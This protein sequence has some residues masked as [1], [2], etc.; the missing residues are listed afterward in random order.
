[1]GGPS[2]D[3]SADH[4]YLIEDFNDFQ[5][6]QTDPNY[7]ATGIHTRLDCDLDLDPNLPDRQIYITAVAPAL[8]GHFDG[9][10]HTI[11]NLII[12]SNGSN[13]SNDWWYVGLFGIIEGYD[14]VVE[15]LG[16]KNVN[17]TI[18]DANFSGEVG[19][20][21]GFNGQC[22]STDRFGG[23]ITNCYVTGTVVGG[24]HAFA[25]GGLCGGNWKGNINDC[26]TTVTV[27]GRDNSEYVGGICG[28]NY[29]N[30]A[31]CYATGAVTGRKDFGGLCGYNEGT[32]TNCHATGL[33]TGIFDPYRFGGLCGYN[34][35][36]II[37][38]YATGKVTGEGNACDLGGLCGF[39][40]GGDVINC[41]AT[42]AVDGN[43]YNG[44]LCGQNVGTINNCYATGAV[45]ENTYN[46]GLC[47]LQRGPYAE[48][49][50]SFW[51]IETSEMTIGYSQDP[52]YPGTITN[53][54]G[55]TT[56][57]MKTVGTF[58]DAGWDLV[59]VWNIEDGQTYPLLRKYSAFDTNYDNKV[60]FI[61]F[62]D[63]A[64]HWLDG[65]E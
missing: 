49:N 44:G 65:V 15:N 26:Y 29:G 1:M 40:Y 54:I 52:E 19:G 30:I 45:D 12:D 48:I 56:A 5:T 50:N 33:V 14:A 7:W 57:E 6:F 47:G 51:D 34:R 60:N 41:Y 31:N 9:N 39:N 4:P 10:D 20:L 22:Y 11:S 64:K 58:L 8:L 16:L 13:D 61:D 36:T 46:G 37:N 21:C 2:Q 3:G 23:T 63:F 43:T 27:T 53:V 59:T 18:T 25:I 28:D 55:K 38:S 17:I 42:G 32:I 24:G 62:A 35:G